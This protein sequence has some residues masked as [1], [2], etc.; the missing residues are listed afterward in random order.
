MTPSIWPTTLADPGIRTEHLYLD[1][2]GDLW[3]CNFNEDRVELL[4]RI[5]EAGDKVP[6]ELRPAYRFLLQ[7]KKESSPPISRRD[8]WR[9][10]HLRQKSLR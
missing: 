1:A 10:R 8:L 2:D 5:W 4:G 7:R 6:T 9:E 3:L